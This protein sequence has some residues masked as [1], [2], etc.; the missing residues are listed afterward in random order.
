[1]QKKKKPGEDQAPPVKEPPK[2]VPTIP[3]IRTDGLPSLV[4]PEVMGEPE[5][6]EEPVKEEPEPPKSA[7][8]ISVAAKRLTDEELTSRLNLEDKFRRG[9]R[10]ALEAI[11]DLR[12]KKGPNGFMWRDFGTWEDYCWA[13]FQH[14]KQWAAQVVKQARMQALMDER[15]PGVE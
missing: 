8:A 14:S 4:Q 7:T 1:A 15:L 11:L 13:T 9:L 10:A 6:Q 5:E 3:L 2:V 12:Y